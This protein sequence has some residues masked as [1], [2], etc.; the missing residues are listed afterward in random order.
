MQL[1]QA[2]EDRG[3]H[4]GAAARCLVEGER[5]QAAGDGEEQDRRGEEDAGVE[6]READG[7]EGGYVGHKVKSRTSKT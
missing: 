4:V 5:L 6:V 2:D 3:R 7:F 1:A